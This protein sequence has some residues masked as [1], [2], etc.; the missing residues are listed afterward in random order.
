VKIVQNIGFKGLIGKIFRNKDLAAKIGP[1][2]A[3]VRV[4]F[5]NFF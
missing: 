1:K 3:F 2:P 4:P 5:V